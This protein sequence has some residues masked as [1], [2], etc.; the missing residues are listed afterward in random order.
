M[1]S[2][3]VTDVHYDSRTN[4]LIGTLL[5]LSEHNGCPI[6]F[7]YVVKNVDDI[8][9]FISE[10]K[11]TIL[12]VVL[13]KNIDDDSPPIVLQVHFYVITR[14]YNI[15][16]VFASFLIVIIKIEIRVHVGQTE[17]LIFKSRKICLVLKNELKLSKST[18]LNSI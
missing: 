5:P 13:A 15:S 7:T 18:F 16:T 9:N 11:S 1:I 17:T 6:P 10:V 8:E 4:Q 3:L 12:Y 2:G 14:I